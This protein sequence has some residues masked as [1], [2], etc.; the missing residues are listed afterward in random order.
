MLVM[1]SSSIVRAHH[2][3]DCRVA[4]DLVKPRRTAPPPSGLRARRVLRAAS[5]GN[6]VMATKLCWEEP[7]VLQLRC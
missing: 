7:L 2:E 5:I 4:L 3:R 6:Y 1:A